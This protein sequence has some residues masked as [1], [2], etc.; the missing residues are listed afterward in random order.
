M[1]VLLPLARQTKRH[2]IV[3]FPG[4]SF[5]FVNI[6]FTLLLLCL[7]FSPGLVVAHLEPVSSVFRARSLR[8]LLFL[9]SE[10]PC[11]LSQVFHVL[12]SWFLVNLAS[13][14]S[15]ESSVPVPLVIFSL[16][17]SSSLPSCRYLAFAFYSFIF[18]YC[19][20]RVFCASACGS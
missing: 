3:A 17:F 12:I 19:G 11:R 8:V 10:P 18:S 20:C 7:R 4:W 9:A 14:V 1:F 13:F 6:S 15:S 2:V 16:L 5:D